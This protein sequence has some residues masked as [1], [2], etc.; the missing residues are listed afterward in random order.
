[1]AREREMKFASLTS[2]SRAHDAWQAITLWGNPG[3]FSFLGHLDDLISPCPDTDISHGS[4]SEVLEPV[5]VGPRR[6]RQVRQSPHLRQ[7]LPPPLQRLI[8]RLHP[9]DSLDV[10]RHTVDL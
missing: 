9:F 5:Y 4:S 2:G 8:D 10:R 6:R 1:M 3:G 7:F